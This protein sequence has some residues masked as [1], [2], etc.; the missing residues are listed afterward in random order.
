MKI[1]ENRLFAHCP[2]FPVSSKVYGIN[3]QD[4]EQP[5]LIHRP[6]DKEQQK[7]S[8]NPEFKSFVKT[9]LVYSTL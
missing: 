5:L 4:L 3:L 8:L 7:V 2:Q 6:K 9:P 1:I